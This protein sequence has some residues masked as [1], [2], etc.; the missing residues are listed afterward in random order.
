MW[1]ARKLHTTAATNI[2]N[3]YCI[4]RGTYIYVLFFAHI[5]F[6][7]H[8]A[9]D[10]APRP[11]GNSEVSSTLAAKIDRGKA[12][13]LFSLDSTKDPAG[14]KIWPKQ[15]HRKLLFFHAKHGLAAFLLILYSQL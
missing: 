8:R 13:A 3:H 14:T 12:S 1:Q 4:I 10:A 7:V 15:L 2:R 11:L 6:V 5:P 9:F